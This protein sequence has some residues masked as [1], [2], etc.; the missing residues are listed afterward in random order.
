MLKLY[1]TL[2]RRLDNFQPINPPHVGLYTCGPTV[3]GTAHLGNLRTYVFEDVL[4]RVLEFNR[5]AVKHVMNITDVGHLTSDADEGEDKIERAARALK[6]DAVTIARQYENEFFRDLERLNVRQPTTILRATETIALQLELIKRLQEKGFTYRTSD[7]LYFDTAKFPRY[8]QLSGQRV[9]EKMAGARVKVNPAKRQPTD[10]ALWKFSPPGAKRQMEW[11]SPWGVGFPGWHVECSAM[12]MK[13]LGEQFDLHTGGIDHISIHHEN[14]IA[15]SEAAT[16]KHPFVR[17]WL[18]G[19]FLILPG[20]RMGKSEGNMLTLDDVAKRGFHPWAFRYLILQTHFRS[21]LAFSWDALAAADQ[22]LKRLWAFVDSIPEQPR[23]GCAEFEERF[24]QA[25]NNDLDT[26]QALAILHEM[27]RSDY[28][29]RAKLQ[30]LAVFD[31]VLGLGLT[32]TAERPHLQPLDA[33]T[34][35]RLSRLIAE[36]EQARTDKNWSRADQLR[37]HINQLLEP[38]GRVLDDTS[39]GPSIRVR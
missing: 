20:Q 37:H 25:V 14:E 31:R 26:P 13:E 12:S 18:H 33:T 30:S 3:Y 4:R 10:F 22:G 29:G 35:E 23:I 19:E 15:Q 16:G 11:S 34:T 9:A 2:T 39:D 17:Y 38:H 32:A 8:G 28:P 36:R 5:F 24:R 6:R 1:N 27:L 7:G 21:K